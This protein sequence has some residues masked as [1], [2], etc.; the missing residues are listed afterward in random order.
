MEAEIISPLKQP[1]DIINLPRPIEPASNFSDINEEAPNWFPFPR[2]LLQF[3]DMNELRFYV[4]LFSR[5]HT[6]SKDKCT[7]YYGSYFDNIKGGE[8]F[9]HVPTA[10]K[11]LDLKPSKL[12]NKLMNGLDSGLFDW[13]I[14]SNDEG[15]KL[16]CTRGKEEP[17]LDYGIY[18][19]IVACHVENPFPKGFIKVSRVLPVEDMLAKKPLY[20]AFAVYLVSRARWNSK[21]VIRQHRGRFERIGRGQLLVTHQELADTFN[22]KRNKVP[23]I[24]NWFKQN[25]LLETRGSLIT[26]SKDLLPKTGVTAGVQKGCN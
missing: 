13:L 17:Y 7:Y 8:I 24:I 21:P 10:S 23:K 16:Y 14:I 19:Q 18:D 3:H 15:G 26:L 22:I 6:V 11:I 9:L 4:Y 2:N 25:E 5:M 20:L 1:A 12:I